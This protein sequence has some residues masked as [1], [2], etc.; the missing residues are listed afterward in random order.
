[1]NRPTNRNDARRIVA[2][3]IG[4]ECTDELVDAVLELTPWR[5]IHALSEAEFVAVVDEAAKFLRA[6]LNAL[7]NDARRIVAVR[8]AN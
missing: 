8:G 2:D 4:P 5:E 7:R 1:V 3:W 6:E